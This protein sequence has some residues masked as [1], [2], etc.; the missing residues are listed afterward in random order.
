[1]SKVLLFAVLILIVFALLA[2][3]PAITIDVNSV[4]SSS[5]FSYIRAALYFVPV[6]TCAAILALILGLQVWRI[7][8]ALVRTIWAVLPI[9]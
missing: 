5:A 8:V 9:K 6:G 3:L 2:A 4:V 1:M 7:I